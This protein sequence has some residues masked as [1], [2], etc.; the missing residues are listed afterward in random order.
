MAYFVT[1]LSVA[2]WLWCAV[3][4]LLL[5]SR[6]WFLSRASLREQNVRERVHDQ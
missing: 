3:V 4:V 5:L 1:I 2:G 6:G